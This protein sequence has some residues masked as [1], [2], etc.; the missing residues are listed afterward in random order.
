M[1]EA[2]LVEENKRL[3]VSSLVWLLGQIERLERS[4]KTVLET[5]RCIIGE[6]TGLILAQHH[7]KDEVQWAVMFEAITRSLFPTKRD[8]EDRGYTVEEETDLMTLFQMIAVVNDGI[9]LKGEVWALL[10]GFPFDQESEQSTPLGLAVRFAAW[11]H[12]RPFPRDSTLS[13]PKE[14]FSDIC[15]HHRNKLH[16][17][18][19][20]LLQEFGILMNENT[21]NGV[22]DFIIDCLTMLWETLDLDEGRPLAKEI[23][24]TML[25]TTLSVMGIPFTASTSLHDRMTMVID[26]FDTQQDTQRYQPFVQALVLQ[27]LLDLCS[28]D[29]KSR[30]KLFQILRHSS[31]ANL[32]KRDLTIR[33]F[34]IP[35][36]RMHFWPYI[37]RWYPTDRTSK[38]PWAIELAAAVKNTIDHLPRVLIKGSDEWNILTIALETLAVCI[39]ANT[40]SEI[41]SVSSS[42]LSPDR[43]FEWLLDVLSNLS[44]GMYDERFGFIVSSMLTGS[45]RNLLRD[46]FYCSDSTILVGAGYSSLTRRKILVN[47]CSD[48]SLIFAACALFGWNYEPSRPRAADA[49]W[50]TRALKGAFAHWDNYE[51]HMFLECDKKLLPEL[52]NREED[53]E[54]WDDYV[55]RFLQR[56]AHPIKRLF[57]ETQGSRPFMEVKANE[58][59][60]EIF[61]TSMVTFGNMVSRDSSRASTNKRLRL[62]VGILKVVTQL[63]AL[64]GFGQNFLKPNNLK[65]FNKLQWDPLEGDRAIKELGFSSYTPIGA[66]NYWLHVMIDSKALKGHQVKAII[67]SDILKTSQ[68]RGAPDVIKFISLVS[69]LDPDVRNQLRRPERGNPTP[70]NICTRILGEIVD[71]QEEKMRS[72]S[73]YWETQGKALFGV[74][75]FQEWRDGVGLLIDK[76]NQ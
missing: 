31:L 13:W 50:G 40:F 43:C 49:A 4:M 54:F 34:T 11:R 58:V 12:K 60:K 74:Q 30:L 73:T 28:F 45:V 51:P 57:V 2:A 3:S 25:S 55:I 7:S 10:T 67:N 68:E 8:W 17:I 71:T 9:T 65:W 29:C 20:V 76:L 27:I 21:E 52:G 47:R 36:S 48:P 64:H 72:N 63:S 24:S 56:R 41:S 18:I 53:N 38:H 44:A 23:R 66:L 70:I 6:D 16:Y 22:R 35:S 39:G 33:S 19:Q 42:D 15:K 59:A 62:H 69:N 37:K 46:A 26:T 5:F 1:W 32:W 61:D 14:L 75:S